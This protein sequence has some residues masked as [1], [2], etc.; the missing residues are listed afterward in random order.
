MP[1]YES[2]ER[3]NQR[4]V[5]LVTTVFPR[6][7]VQGRLVDSVVCTLCTCPNFCFI[8]GIKT[9]II[10]ISRM[11]VVVVVVVVVVGMCTA[12]F[13]VLR[14]AQAHGWHGGAGKQ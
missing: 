1:T 9:I 7:H 8:F 3:W 10:I 2:S 13:F 5:L 4:V 14:E 12:I 6:E 11:V